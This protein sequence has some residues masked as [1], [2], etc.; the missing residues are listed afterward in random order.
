MLRYDRD[1][2]F[3]MFMTCLIYC[4]LIS[5]LLNLFLIGSNNQKILH[6]ISYSPNLWEK[7]LKPF[8][9]LNITYTQAIAT[10]Q[11][12]ILRSAGFVDIQADSQHPLS[13][14][15][16]WRGQSLKPDFLGLSLSHHRDQLTTGEDMWWGWRGA[17]CA[18]CWAEE[19]ENIFIWE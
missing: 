1:S 4:L 6:Y 9:A 13:S 12:R 15:T 10:L 18:T 5:Q 19:T 8:T 16:Y 17:V 7:K 2:Y 11:Q 14:T 3:C